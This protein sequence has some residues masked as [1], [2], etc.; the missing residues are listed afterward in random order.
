METNTLLAFG[1][2]I[3]LVYLIGRAM[4]VP[5]KWIFKL[6]INA[7]MGGVVLWIV[8]FFG[9]YIDFH[10]P[11]NPVTALIVGFLGIPGTILLVVV[12]Q[13]IGN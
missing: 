4:L 7:V 10:I 13:I 3:L 1:L 11:L 9:A 8:N 12:Q 6:L 2:G 5:F